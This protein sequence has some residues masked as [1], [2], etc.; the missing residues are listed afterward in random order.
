MSPL[1]SGGQQDAGF[2]TTISSNSTFTPVIWALSR[3]NQQN[4][5]LFAFDPDNLQGG[6]MNQLF[7]GIAGYWPNTTAN[8][9]LVPVVANGK[10]YVASY[11]QLTIF[12]LTTQARRNRT[13]AR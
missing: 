1:V 11:K 13:S 2:F 8:A 9:N 4:I 10:V 7:Q 3:A 5:S 6:L 12:G